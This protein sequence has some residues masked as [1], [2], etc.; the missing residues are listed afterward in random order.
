M[1][2]E[3][4]K[5][6]KPGYKTTEFYITLGL[7]V[8]GALW[9]SGLISEGSMLDKLLGFGAMVAAQFGYSLSRGMVKKAQGGFIQL[10][11]CL[12]IAL[13]V[14]VVAMMPGCPTV[15]NTAKAMVNCTKPDVAK[16][17]SQFVPATQQVILSA[18]AA[19]G[20]VDWAPIERATAN[21]VGDVGGCVMAEAVRGLLE[22]K[23]GDGAVMSAP[24]AFDKAALERNWEL[25]RS[26]KYG[27][28]RYKLSTGEF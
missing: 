7:Y 14:L 18:V 2:D 11:L 9:G 5:P 6:M 16:L 19:D 15:K 4:K 1:S 21:Y 25:T 20:S 24:A 12:A 27:G 28:A 23:Q 13:P 26:Q 22:L 17:V 8:L 3:E 10:R